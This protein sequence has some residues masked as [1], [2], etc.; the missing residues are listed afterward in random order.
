MIAQGRNSAEIPDKE[1][2]PKL[3]E[4]VTRNMIHG[5]CGA[6]NMNSPCMIDRKYSKRFPRDFINETQH[7]EGG[8]PLY[9]RRKPEDGGFKASIKNR[10]EIIEVDNRWVVPYS[11]VLLRMFDAH[12]NVEN[13]HS[14]KSIFYIM[15][16]IHKSED[17]GVFGIQDANITINEIKKYEAG[18]YISSNEAAWRILGFSIH[19]R[20]PPVTHLSV[21]LQNGQ[22]VYFNDQ[23]FMQVMLNPPQTTL[24]AFFDLCNHDDFAKTLF[25][26][27]VPKYFTWDKSAKQFK[28]RKQGS[29]VEGHQGI[30]ETDTLGRIYT[31]HPNNAE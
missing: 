16:Y 6:L 23:N 15:K 28:R 30:K 21:H 31:V 12:I 18:R 14:V 10:S 2:D 27:E 4:I 20:Y 1:T 13:C 19:D 3:Y 17:R 11:P 24:T 7:G 26:N 8:Y 9:R 5:P 25:Y 29:D 22:R